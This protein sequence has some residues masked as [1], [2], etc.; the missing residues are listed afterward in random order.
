MNEPDAHLSAGDPLSEPFK[1]NSLVVIRAPEV[2]TV[3]SVGVIVDVCFEVGVTA[4]LLIAHGQD[5]G[6]ERKC[7]S[8]GAW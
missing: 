5:G 8:C 2:L 7:R 3:S 6:G 1:G 4:H